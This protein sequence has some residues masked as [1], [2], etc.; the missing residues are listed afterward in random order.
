[1]RT[2]RITSII[3]DYGN[4][5]D[6][7]NRGVLELVLLL[8][9]VD[10]SAD[11]VSKDSLLDR[12][13]A[14]GARPSF[15]LDSIKCCGKICESTVCDSLSSSDS[16]SKNKKENALRLKKYRNQIVNYF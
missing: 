3:S 10:F 7:P 5:Q 16:P 2:Y 14:A 6:E 13:R 9:S 15:S 8:I 4:S 11:N 1:M 12:T